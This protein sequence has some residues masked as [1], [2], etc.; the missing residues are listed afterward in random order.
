MVKVDSPFYELYIFLAFASVTYSL[1]VYLFCQPIR[2]IYHITF[3]SLPF[4]LESS[5]ID[6]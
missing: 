3:H 5:F 1:L 6:R 4:V 2:P